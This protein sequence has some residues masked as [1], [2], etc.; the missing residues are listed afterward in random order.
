MFQASSRT[1]LRLA[2]LVWGCAGVNLL[3][4]GLSASRGAGGWPIWAGALLIFLL[5][6]RGV[7]TPLVRRHTLRI[8]SY[9]TP[10]WFW[11]FFD[12]KSFLIMVFMMSLGVALR[13]MAWVPS[14]FFA[15]FYPGLGG[16]LLAAGLSFGR[17]AWIQERSVTNASHL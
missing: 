3:R 6:Q 13:R 11:R 7:F 15:C 16:A 4:V 2:A 17:N 1:L 10:Q 9:T 14:W 8:R 5:F 12:R